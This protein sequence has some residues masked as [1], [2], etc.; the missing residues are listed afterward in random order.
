MATNE[1]ST[2][3]FQVQY[4]LCD[5]NPKM[6]Q[7]WQELFKDHADR[8]QIHNGHI[9]GK[10]APSADAIVSPANSFGFM[11]GGIDMVYTRHFGW[12]MQERLQEVIRKEYNGEVL[13]GQAAIIETF[14]GGVKEG[15]L[16]WSKYNGGQPIKFLI[17]A[18]TMRVPLEVADT[19]NA[20]LA[21]RAVILAVKKHNAVPANEPIRSVLCPGLGTAVGR[22]PPE[23]CAFQMCRAFEVYELGMHKN[24]LNPTHLEYPCADHETMTQYV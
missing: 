21:F 8:I 20:Y 15:S 3:D 13:V 22:M 12:Q 24:V 17:S 23:R 11:D 7:A 19:V 9:F 14:E 1:V 5:Y 18:P 4:K 16:D 10:D 6:V 2:N